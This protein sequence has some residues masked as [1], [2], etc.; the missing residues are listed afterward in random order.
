M[1]DGE[2]RRLARRA[3][4]SETEEDQACLGREYLRVS[5]DQGDVFRM[6]VSIP[7]SNQ[8]ELETRA[9]RILFSY[10]TPVAFN[11]KR[12]GGW[13]RSKGPETGGK[14]S[15]TTVKHVNAWLNRAPTDHVEAVDQSELESLLDT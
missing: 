10:E 12:T 2:L 11:V 13:F 6:R 9:H 14:W 1:S 4:A 8:L 15:R 3:L 7:G 5:A